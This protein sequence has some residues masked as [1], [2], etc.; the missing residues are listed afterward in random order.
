MTSAR[1]PLATYCQFRSNSFEAMH[2]RLNAVLKPHSLRRLSNVPVSGIICCATLNRISINLMRIGPAVEVWPGALEKFYLV[3]VPIRGAVQIRQGKDDVCCAGNVAAV[4]SPGEPLQLS[5]S[6]NCTQLIV[7]IPRDAIESRLARQ[8]GE[9][10]QAMVRFRTAFD[11]DGPSGREW[12]RLLNFAVRTVDDRGVFSRGPLDA[13]LEDLLLSGL[14]V[15]QSHNYS[16]ARHRKCETTPCYVLRAERYMREC[17]ARPLTIADLAGAA[18]VSERA[19]HG[20]FRRFRFTTP[21]RRL[22]AIR[23][24]TARHRLQQGRPGLTV[25][26]AAADVGCFQFGHFARSYRAMFGELPSAT[27]RTALQRA[28]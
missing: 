25:S 3:Q 12:R 15:A 28:A 10:P 9:R 17:F 8:I 24:T 14:L 20:G 13:D 16:D 4:V 11:L 21:M 6:D 23:L 19:L 26:R 22:N 1:L 2:H 27:L 18:G 5:W 7:Q